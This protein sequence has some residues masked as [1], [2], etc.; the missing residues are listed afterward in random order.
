[1]TPTVEGLPPRVL[2]SEEM[3]DLR[4]MDEGYLSAYVQ[5]GDQ[6][7]P[8]TLHRSMTGAP[9]HFQYAGNEGNAPYA[10]AEVV[11][12]HDPN[13]PSTSHGRRSGPCNCGGAALLDGLVK[14]AAVAYSGHTFDIRDTNQEFHDQGHNRRTW[15]AWGHGVLLGASGR[16]LS[17]GC[18]ADS[19]SD[20]RQAEQAGWE[21]G[22]HRVNEGEQLRCDRCRSVLS[23]EEA[24]GG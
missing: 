17:E 20:Y 5:L 16:R 3:E 4:S 13:C 2:S 14:W 18:Y 22:R 10:F 11:V 1:M 9:L 6:R 15:A 24:A 8:L 7:L 12:V 23:F 19:Q 21:E